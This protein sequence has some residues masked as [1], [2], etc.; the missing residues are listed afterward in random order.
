MRFIYIAAWVWVAGSSTLTLALPTPASEIGGNPTTSV[1]VAATHSALAPRQDWDWGPATTAFISAIPQPTYGQP[2]PQPSDDGSW[3][4]YDDVPVASETPKLPA[5]GGYTAP[6]DKFGSRAMLVVFGVIGFVV[7]ILAVWAFIAHRH[8][9]HPFACFGR[10]TRRK[11]DTE[12]AR[13]DSTTSDIPLVGAGRHYDH[14]PVP[15]QPQ[16]PPVPTNQFPQPAHLDM[17]RRPL[18]DPEWARRF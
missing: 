8:G 15:V 5:D 11:T 7:L 12:V 9:R 3:V 1:G 18:S 4:S 2:S 10:C 16:M 6:P 13:G 14:R 17:P